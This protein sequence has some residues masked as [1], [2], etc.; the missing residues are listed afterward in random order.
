MVVLKQVC[1]T[2]FRRATPCSMRKRPFFCDPKIPVSKRISAFYS[3]CVPTVLHGSGEWACTQ[4]MF[5][6]LRSWGDGVNYD[7][8]CAFE[9]DQMRAG[10]IF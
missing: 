2:G 8:F 5:Q 3:T 1:G 4:G 7:V 9:D 6:S 10:L